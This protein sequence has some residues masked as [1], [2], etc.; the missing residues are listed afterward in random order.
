MDILGRV[1]FSE[2]A[3]V[4]FAGVGGGEP[5]APVSRLHGLVNGPEPRRALRVMIQHDVLL[6]V[7]VA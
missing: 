3:V 6:T 5:V 4:D 1:D 7:A 2:A